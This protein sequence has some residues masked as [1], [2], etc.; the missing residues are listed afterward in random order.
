M[1]KGFTLI[2][3]ITTTVVIILLITSISIAYYRSIQPDTVLSSTARTIASDLRLASEMASTTQVNHAIR[4][5]LPGGYYSLMRL[6]EPENTIKTEY[7]EA[8]ITFSQTTLPNN[9]AEFN[10]LGAAVASGTI[11]LLYQDGPTITLHIRPSGYV[12]IE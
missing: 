3:L 7:L 12:R 9:S 11:T 5:N 2:E 6:S 1:K 10:T 8:T 4:F